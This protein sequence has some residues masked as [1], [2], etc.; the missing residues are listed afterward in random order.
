[1]NAFIVGAKRTPFGAFGGSLASLSATELGTI[2]TTAAIGG[3][4]TS[5][6]LIDSVYFGNVIQSSKDAAYLARHVALQSDCPQ[7]TPALTIN[8]LCGSGFESVI[9]SVTAIQT[10]QS[11]ISIAGGTESMS[12][13][14]LVSYTARWGSKLGMGVSLGDALWDGLT[15]SYAQTPM[16]V[17][18]ENLAKQYAI[19]REVCQSLRIALQCIA[20]IIITTS[21]TGTHFCLGMR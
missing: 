3:A 13:A 5:A 16:G 8:R 1:M 6:S 2:A 7:T 15:D 9:Q 14:P 17:T 19:S 18:A 12:Q 21:D 20:L 10:E 4:K 11:Q